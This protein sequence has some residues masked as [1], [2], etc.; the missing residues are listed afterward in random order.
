MN[1]D[2]GD[3]DE[4]GD[5]LLRI[6]LARAIARLRNQE[7]YLGLF[8]QGE[9]DGCWC[10]W[11]SGAAEVDSVLDDVGGGVEKSG[12]HLSAAA[13]CTDHLSEFN[14]PARVAPARVVATEART[15]LRHHRD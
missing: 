13:A 14:F 15:T 1:G 5:A 8:R 11:K 9:H 7:N 4:L 3:V 2:A 6:R 12:T 10:W